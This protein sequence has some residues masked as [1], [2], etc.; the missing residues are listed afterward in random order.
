M[1]VHT[2]TTTTNTKRRFFEESFV[3]AIEGRRSFADVL[4]Q[5]DG[6]GP[7]RPI[8]S[9]D[10]RRRPKRKGEVILKNEDITDKEARPVRLRAPSPCVDECQTNAGSNGRRSQ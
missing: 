2:T 7:K 10:T 3:D 5:F 1:P 4:R 8:S 6:L 9:S